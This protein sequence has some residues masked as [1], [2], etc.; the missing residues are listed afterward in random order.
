M[1]LSSGRK[2]CQNYTKTRIKKMLF[3]FHKLNILKWESHFWKSKINEKVYKAEIDT[4]F[5]LYRP[6]YRYKLKHFTKAWRTDFPLQAK[7]GGWYMD[8]NN[9]TEEQQYYMKTANDSASWQMS[10]QG[11]L[12][13]KKHKPLY[14][15]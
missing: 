4:T 10:K 2:I 15:K 13:N 14:S 1:K 6:R 12:I 7:H 3:K 9:L 8:I 11:E 5:A